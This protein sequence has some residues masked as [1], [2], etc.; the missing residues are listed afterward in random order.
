MIVAH[1]VSFLLCSE[2]LLAELLPL[3]LHVTC[4]ALVL[5]LQLSCCTLQ[6]VCCLLNLHSQSLH[7]QDKMRFSCCIKHYTVVLSHQLGDW[8]FR[9]MKCAENHILKICS[10]LVLLNKQLPQTRSVG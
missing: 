1:L 10:S 2:E 8:G 5:L 9:E 6:I 7:V 3:L 4:Q